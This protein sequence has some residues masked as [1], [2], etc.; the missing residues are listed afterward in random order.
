MTGMEGTFDNEDMAGALHELERYGD[1]W[2][3]ERFMRDNRWTAL[4]QTMDQLRRDVLLCRGK[5][6]GK[7][8]GALRK[9]Y[10]QLQTEHDGNDPAFFR[11]MQSVYRTYR[12]ILEEKGAISRLRWLMRMRAVPQALVLA[13]EWLPDEF[14]SRKICILSDGRRKQVCRARA[15]RKRMKWTVYFMNNYRPGGAAPQ[16]DLAQ[17]TAARIRRMCWRQRRAPKRK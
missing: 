13:V 11:V 2:R 14:F 4:W 7:D 10:A 12:E 9:I 16:D 8:A 6:I 5:A 15:E 17:K 1:P 3:L